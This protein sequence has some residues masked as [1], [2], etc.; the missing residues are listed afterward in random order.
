MPKFRARIERLKRRTLPARSVAVIRTRYKRPGSQARWARNRTRPCSARSP[1]SMRSPFTAR[2]QRRP[3]G[4]V[5]HTKD[6]EPSRI[7][8]LGSQHPDD[9]RRAVRTD[10]FP[11]RAQDW[12]GKQNKC[13]AQ[14]DA[15][16]DNLMPT[17]TLE[18]RRTFHLPAYAQG[19]V[20]GSGPAFPRIPDVARRR[21]AARGPARHARARPGRTSGP[22]TRSR[23]SCFTFA[24][25]ELVE[26]VFKWKPAEYNVSE[27]RQVMEPVTGPVHRSCCSRRAAHAHAQADAAA[28]S[29]AGDRALRGAHRAGPNGEIDTWRGPRSARARSRKG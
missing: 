21:A 7:D 2:C 27:P 10:R 28:V 17:I 13:R 3:A 1:T 23:A 11:V 8:S 19:L 5:R 22:T 12:R 14:G 20:G 26:Q 18:A 15:H 4:C 29:P 25:R 24:E 6:D 9:R 16:A